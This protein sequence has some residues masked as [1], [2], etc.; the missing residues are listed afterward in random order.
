MK[1][2][3]TNPTI[4]SRIKEIRMDA[5]MKQGEFGKLFGVSPSG[6]SRWELGETSNMKREILIKMSDMFNVNPLW[7]MGLD[8]P[9]AKPT[10]AQDALMQE[11]TDELIWLDEDKLRKL[12]RFMEEFL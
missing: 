8:V 4:A 6:V 12:K 7:I 9:K 3:T 5:G 1:N 11:I 2:K 10:K